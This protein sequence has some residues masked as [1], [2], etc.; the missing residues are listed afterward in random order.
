[1][2]H[3][4]QD[5]RVFFNFFCTLYDTYG[6]PFALAEHHL[7]SQR[8][9]P[10]CSPRSDPSLPSSRIRGVTIDGSKS[11]LQGAKLATLFFLLER[12]QR[13]HFRDLL[14]LPPKEI[15]SKLNP[16]FVELANLIVRSSFRICS[17]HFAQA[18]YKTVDRR[19]QSNPKWK[20]V[21]DLLEE[22]KSGSELMEKVELE[23]KVKDFR[24]A[25]MDF[26]RFHQSLSKSTSKFF[27][28]GA[29]NFWFGHGE[30]SL[31]YYVFPHCLDLRRYLN[32][33]SNAIEACHTARSRP[34]VANGGC[35][36]LRVLLYSFLMQGKRESE[37]LA[38]KLRYTMRRTE[39]I[40]IQPDPDES[41]G[42]NEL[43][44]ATF[45][46]G[47]NQGTW[48]KNLEAE[49]KARRQLVQ[50]LGKDHPIASGSQLIQV[51]IWRVAMSQGLPPT[52]SGFSMELRGTA[53]AI[54]NL[55]NS[56]T[57]VPLGRPSQ[58]TTRAQRTSSDIQAI[59][60]LFSALHEDCA[61]I[62]EV[63]TIRATLFND[64][65]VSP[66]SDTS[67]C[68]HVIPIL[69]FSNEVGSDD[70]VD[71]GIPNC[72]NFSFPVVH[73]HG[74]LLCGVVFSQRPRTASRRFL[75]RVDRNQVWIYFLRNIF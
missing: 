42:G 28:D 58:P 53:T 1:M 40:P 22:L 63:Q 74:F 62:H 57:F 51:L 30:D 33:T 71:D 38:G 19:D 7:Q 72:S 6:F 21:V 44:V 67:T 59:A 61:V 70:V 68:I 2:V 39:L 37:R 27:S 56:L 20:A 24:N 29:L 46:S 43:Y 15:E 41:V 4:G 36:D 8:W 64:L 45:G 60:N 5:F 12:S 69:G 32:P 17:F 48:E 16:E 9:K 54:R 52:E 75:L 25:I 13:S 23:E 10:F 50:N 18:L 35:Q 47:G 3:T 73:P 55:S 31:I 66:T 14:C 49:V 26:R 11:Q 34:V 65:L